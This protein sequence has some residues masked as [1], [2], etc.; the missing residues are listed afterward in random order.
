MLPIALGAAQT[1]LALLFLFA[2]LPKVLGRGLD[3][4]TGF[5]ALPRPLTV[6]I[7]VAEIAGALALALPPLLGRLE[8][9]TPLAAVGLAV[10][11]LM[12]AGFHLRAAEW[13]RATETALWALLCGAVAVGRWDALVTGPDLAPDL[14]TGLL[15]P[16]IWLP[17]VALA[18]N[19][20][21]ILRATPRPVDRRR[22]AR[23]T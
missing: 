20:A 13:L 21:A 7:G 3:R 8:W 10:V 9:V 22:R 19:L 12:A 2:G 17:L 1:V 4:W 16:A 14:G 15:A 18:V 6:L 11:T 23:R 5:D